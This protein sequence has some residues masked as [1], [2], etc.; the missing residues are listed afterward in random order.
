[1]KRDLFYETGRIVCRLLCSTLWDYKAYGARHVPLEGGVLLASN[2]QSYLDPVLV[3]LPVMRPVSFMARS[4]LFE[5]PI[6][7]RLIRRLYAFPVHL[8]QGDLRA[9][10][11]MIDRLAQGH[12][13]VMFPEGTRTETGDVKPLESGIGLM[14]R[15][16]GV[17]VVPVAIHGSFEAWPRSRKLPQ[18]HPVRVMY[19]APMKLDHL[20]AHQIVAEIEG[21]IRTMAGQLRAMSA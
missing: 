5:N 14:V 4:E 21:A 19:G 1:M 18:S 6:F 3:A 8:G 16:A 13:V 17:P 9:I 11:E 20:K 2:H 12:A 7:G 10:R 15:R